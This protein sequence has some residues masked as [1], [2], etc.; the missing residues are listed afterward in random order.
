MT[1]MIA[2]LLSAATVLGSV[3][4][5]GAV[6]SANPAVPTVKVTQQNVQV[7]ENM[8]ADDRRTAQQQRYWRPP[9]RRDHRDYDDRYYRR[10]HHHGGN[11]GAI[12]GGLA[13]GAIIGGALASQPRYAPRR[14]GN[15]HVEWCYNRY[16][17]Y[18]AYDNSF[19]PN[20]GPRQQC[21]SPY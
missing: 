5:A 18:R 14:A 12:I 21:V 20:Y 4:P 7:A 3:M 2:I 17:S 15:A 19:Q 16:R 8:W 13:A 6:S 9:P 10:H 1:R 11:A